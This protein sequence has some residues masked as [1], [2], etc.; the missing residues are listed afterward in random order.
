MTE[1]GDLINSYETPTE[2]SNDENDESNE[3]EKN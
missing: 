2:K 1:V 3:N